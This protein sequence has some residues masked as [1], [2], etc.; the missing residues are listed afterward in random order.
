VVVEDHKVVEEILGM[1]KVVVLVV[2]PDLQVSLPGLLEVQ[3]RQI[4]VLRVV[5]LI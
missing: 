5:T 4:R 1:P 3:E 2:V